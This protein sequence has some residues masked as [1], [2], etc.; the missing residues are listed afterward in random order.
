LNKKIENFYDNGSYKKIGNEEKG[1]T[2]INNH[3]ISG[4]VAFWLTHE[5]RFYDGRK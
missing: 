2:G 3:R 5:K 4:D 1:R